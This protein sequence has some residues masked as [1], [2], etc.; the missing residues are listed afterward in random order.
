MISMIKLTGQNLIAGILS[1]KGE[2]SYQARDP[3]TLE[4]ST[5]VFTDATAS[6][7]AQA[8][9]E[10]KQAS[11][12][13]QKDK[14]PAFLREVSNQIL[15]LGDQLLEV[16]ESETALGSPRLISERTR[17]CDQLVKFADFIEDESFK[18][19]V[20]ERS[21]NTKSPPK[22]DIRRM[23]IPLGPVV[24]FPAS[25]FPFAFGVCGGDSSSAWAAGCPVIVKAHPSH[26]ATSELFGH[27]VNKAI[28]TCD[29][30][31]GYFSLI[32]GNDVKVSKQLVTHPEVEAI[33][34]TG[35][36][37]VGRAIFD[38]A[39]ARP[40]PIPVFA[41]M[42]C[43]NPVFISKV[44][45]DTAEQL[46]GS[47]SLGTGQFCTKPGV[48]FVKKN[49]VSLIDD[50]VQLLK[51]KEPGILLNETIQGNL[52]R[53]VSRSCSIQSVNVRLGGHAIKDKVSF[54][55]TVLVTDAK[56]YLENE[57]L[58]NEHFGP[59][60]LFVV[61][62]DE[63]DFLKIA[64]SLEGQLTA[65]IHVD[66]S[67]TESISELFHL[68]TRKVGRLIINGVPTGVEVCKAMHHGGPYPA[69]TS[70]HTTSVGMYAIKR[71][72]RPI[73]FQNI[74]KTLLPH[75]LR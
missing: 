48:I 23:L 62:D 15:A 37:R 56:T 50:V 43:I 11:T 41:E 24:V 53:V 67:N 10:A 72:L 3:R 58:H 70:I 19:I 68:L 71:F 60:A 20:I 8:L 55:N 61:C 28:D 39:S 35:S 12:Q 65:T 75:E 64:H 26:P 44:L 5:L 40:K 30:P 34:F 13:V 7:I 73:V 52:D 18:E 31:K 14:I 36:Q 2:R 9:E 66:T 25:N 4:E 45:S 57:V 33:G 29:M 32:H 6:E 1:S 49:D 47:I 69:T 59:V 42:G 46:A 74:P 16:A 27:A 38:L 17:T 22:P 51:K 63:S 21:D 54:E